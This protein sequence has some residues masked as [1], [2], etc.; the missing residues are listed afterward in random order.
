ML[1]HDNHK[2]FLASIVESSQDS[3]VS[4]DFDMVITTWNHAA[5]VIYGY[6]AAEAVGKPLTMLTLPRDLVELMTNVELIRQG[7][8]RHVT[9]FETERRHKDGSPLILEV[10]LSPVKNDEGEI[11]GVST[12]ARDLTRLKEAE[13]AVR[14]RD[15]LHRLLA[16]QEQERRRIAR[17][18][19]D[20]MGQLVTSLRFKLKAAKSSCK[21]EPTCDAIDEIELIAQEI[22]N[23]VDFIAWELRPPSLEGVTLADAI[24]NYVRQ[25]MRYTRVNVQFLPRGLNEVRVAPEVETALYRIVQESLN[26]TRKHAMAQNVQLLMEKRDGAISLIIED[27]GE[28]FDAEDEV[29]QNEGMGLTGMKERAAIIG[30]TM[31]IESTP[32]EGTSVY[33]RV[34]A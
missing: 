27:D 33:V 12:I 3:I 25:W 30:G 18:L 5:E 19:H 16:S 4:I 1:N 22:D 10:V 13:N 17:D 31:K 14:E 20:E 32:G 23:S 26:N 24:Q 6:T 34:P 7:E 9:V 11:V 29:L 28:G 21:D 15:I 8:G 2:Y